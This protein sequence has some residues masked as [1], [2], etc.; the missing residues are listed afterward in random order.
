[1]EN[2]L[3]NITSSCAAER[4]RAFTLLELLVG[5][6]VSGIVLT[7][8]FSAYRIVSS[9]LSGFE[10][11]TAYVKEISLFT[12]QLGSD[13]SN[14][15]TITCISPQEIRLV[16]ATR[17]IDYRFA[18]SYVLRNDLNRTDTFRVVVEDMHA[19]K[20]NEKV[21]D[22]DAEIDELHLL[23]LIDGKKEE[24]VLRQ[25]TDASAA[26]Q[27]EEQHNPDLKNNR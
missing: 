6:V 18:G 14:A 21:D 25:A 22:G 1:M 27:D 19:L 4:L 24:E 20:N 9:Q 26:M 17:Q 5:M 23:L 7:T 15:G 2:S 12:S 11:Q 8:T 3:R 10:R 13:F 16:S